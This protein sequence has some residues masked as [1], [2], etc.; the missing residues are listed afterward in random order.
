MVAGHGLIQERKIGLDENGRPY[1]VIEF[2]VTGDKIPGGADA[3]GLYP[4]HNKSFGQ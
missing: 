2:E 3:S 4:Q 1:P